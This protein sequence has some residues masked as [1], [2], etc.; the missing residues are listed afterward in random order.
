MAHCMFVCL[1]L[2]THRFAAKAS[3][4]SILFFGSRGNKRYTSPCT[5]RDPSSYEVSW[6]LRETRTMPMDAGNRAL[7]YFYRNPPPSSAVKP[8]AFP[9]IAKLVF[10]T[11]GGRPTPSAVRKCVNSF[12]RPKAK[13]GRKL[14]WRKTTLAED[15]VVLKR[16]LKVRPPGCGVDSRDVSKALPACLQGKICLRT[17]RNRLKEKGYTPQPKLAKDD[18][19]RC[20]REPRIAFCKA[21]EHRS[22]GQWSNYL[23][24]CGDLKDFT[25]YPKSLKG[26]FARYRAPWTYM[27]KEEKQRPAFFRPR[28][29]FRRKEFKQTKKGKVFGITLST[30]H[31]RLWFV[32]TP[33]TQWVFAKLVRRQLGPFLQ[34]CFPDRTRFRILLDGEKLLHAPHAKEAC[35][36]VGIELLDSWPHYSPDLNP[37]EN[38]WPW[39]ES[40]LRKSEC[41]TDTFAVFKR[42]L[43]QV[44]KTYPDAAKLIPSMHDRIADC[45]RGKGAM[46]KH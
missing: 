46:T 45:L 4:A 32:T 8:C 26:R 29:M 22:P 43:L 21:N 33:F 44:G 9:E 6:W 30:G 7:C 2:T 31:Q 39:V 11:D 1:A 3:P 16:F 10:K 17:I 34:E 25:Y 23:Q 24:A 27:S 42:R 18:L 36:E 41:K 14:G 38:V 20:V 37:Q 28:H 19:Q 35:D 40:Q 5:S 15:R 13:R 12:S